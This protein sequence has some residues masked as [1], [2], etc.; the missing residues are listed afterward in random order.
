MSYPRRHGN[1]RKQGEEK[2]DGFK[3]ALQKGITTTLRKNFDLRIRKDLVTC[4]E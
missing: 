2:G 3:E 1:K 4:F